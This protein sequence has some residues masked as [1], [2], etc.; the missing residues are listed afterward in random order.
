[1]G[2]KLGQLEDI[3]DTTT[4]VKIYEGT[5]LVRIMYNDNNDKWEAVG[6]E[7]LFSF[8]EDETKELL[9]TSIEPD[10]YCV[11]VYVVVP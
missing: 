1:M 4:E 8:T 3:L 6:Y 2:I 9:V 7:D 10:D 5:F 11:K